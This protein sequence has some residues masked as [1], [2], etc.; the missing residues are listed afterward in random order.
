M[1][2]VWRHRIIGACMAVCAVMLSSPV[3]AQQHSRL[4]K[5]SLRR[6]AAHAEGGAKV[7]AY[8]R[9]ARL[10]RMEVR[11]EGVL[12]TLLAIYDTL[13][14]R[15][16][17]AGDAVGEGVT[18]Y[19]R[20]SVL[21]DCR[22]YEELISR[23]PDVIGFFAA[24]GLWE[25]YYPTCW[26]FVEAYRRRAE[27]DRALEEANK[28]YDHAKKRGDRSGMGLALHAVARIYTDQRRFPEAEKCLRESI[29]M[30]EHEDGQLHMLATVSNHLVQNLIAQKRYDEALEAARATE[31]VNHRYEAASKRPQPSAWFNLWLT[32]TDI[33]R[34]TEAF[35]KA[36]LYVDRIDSIS[37]GSVRMY[38]ERGHILY[39]RKRYR[40]A[41][42]ML[43]SA[44]LSA[45]DPLEAKS[46][47]LVTLMRMREPEKSVALF[48]EV[49]DELEAMHNR[50]YN[51]RLD[52]I[53][54][55]YEVDKYI[56][57][58]ERNR[59]YFLF[60]LGG[61]LL[62][63]V[64]L[65]VAAYYNRV[66]TRKNLGLYRRIREQ[67]LL[68]E[69]LVLLRSEAA[70]DGAAAV[71]EEHAAQLPGD[72]QQRELV[73]RLHE[74]LLAGDRLADADL[75]RDEITS[76][77]GT[78][79][80]ALTEAVRAVTGKTPMEYMRALRIDEARRMIDLHPELTIE[81]VAFSSGFNI[82]S[83]FYRLFRKQ[84][85]IS[86]AEYRK[87]AQTQA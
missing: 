71:A 63:A 69:E 68:E 6:A 50:E 33:Y 45:P 1:K 48:T 5:D 64:L 65:G 39:G 23:A 2:P 87:M 56:A 49:V 82:P 14:I 78:N 70:A 86:P 43:D 18:G 42:A 52:E 61:C 9:L 13:E 85:G 27:Y 20:L 66:I 41:L 80:N 72:R 51:A 31:A 84:Y 10:Y 37:R 38:K 35:D 53:R 57:E 76:A 28:V 44:I 83:T 25:H 74:Y 16:H 55:Q 36:Q 59:N 58:K 15:A 46:L 77:L 47:K 3:W 54:T 17:E 62:L 4:Q 12:D 26:L 67:D 19:D 60:A 75:G 73:A 29:G 24:R 30:L 81:A 40:E 11:R 34:Q 7:D 8:R 32:M 21:A 79:K 22:Q